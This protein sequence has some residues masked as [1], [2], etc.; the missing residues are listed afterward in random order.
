MAR[1]V[2][3]T[4][5]RR[6]RGRSCYDEYLVYLEL[7]HAFDRIR[8]N[9]ERT[10][11]V[12]VYAISSAQ[13]TVRVCSVAVLG[14]SWA[15]VY[16]SAKLELFKAATNMDPGIHNP[17]VFPELRDDSAWWRHQWM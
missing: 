16:E 15:S 11:A 13:K 9:W 5:Y 4:Y 14:A 12:N 10:Q 7:R 2:E 3:D 6:E 1:R 8:S 17:S